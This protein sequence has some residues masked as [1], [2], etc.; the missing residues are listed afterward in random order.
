M[1][2]NLFIGFDE[3]GKYCCLLKTLASMEMIK[4]NLA[5]LEE[6][7]FV[8]DSTNWRGCDKTER[9][10]KI[11]D[12]EIAGKPLFLPHALVFSGFDYDDPEY[13]W[14]FVVTKIC[15]TKKKGFSS[16]KPF[17]EGGTR[18]F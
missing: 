5:D 8:H 16:V 18:D 7:D 3:S 11:M 1:D 9:T 17:V 14:E 15:A 12:L 13:A 6:D 4:N 10:L 2:K